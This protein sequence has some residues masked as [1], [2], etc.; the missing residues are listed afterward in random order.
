MQLSQIYSEI[1]LSLNDPNNDRWSQSVLLPRINEAMTDI[2]VQTNAVK[3]REDLTPVVSTREV[4]VDTDTIDIIRVHIMNSAGKWKKLDGILPEQLDFEYPNWQQKDDG[5]PV[6]YW[7]DGTN[8]KLNLVPKPSSEWAQTNGLR[9]WEV[10]KP[11]DLSSTTDVPYSSN[12]AMIPYHR[13][14]VHYVSGVC[15]M[16][17]GTPEALAKS[18]FH[19]S[20]DFQRPGEYEREIKKIWKKFDAPEDVPARILWAPEGGRASRYGVRTKDNPLGV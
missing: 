3:T 9:V 14:I 6:L 20:N 19:K 10:Q 4:Q 5:E 17:D 11:T 1:G 8:Q 15:W 18:R 16:D 12:A 2:L 7:W 13:A